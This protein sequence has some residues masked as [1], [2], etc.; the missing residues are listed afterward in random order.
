M[1]GEKT[2]GSVGPKQKRPK[3]LQNHTSV[4]PKSKKDHQVAETTT[5]TDRAVEGKDDAFLVQAPKGE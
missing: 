3:Q 2:K 4:E 1:N 5:F